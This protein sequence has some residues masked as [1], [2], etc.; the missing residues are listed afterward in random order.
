MKKKSKQLP[1]QIYYP[2]VIPDTLTDNIENIN[3][4]INLHQNQLDQKQ[5]DYD[6]V[7]QRKIAS[8][9]EDRKRME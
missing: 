3:K 2:T 4:A 6:L 5:K 9:Q 7:I 1:Q 8:T